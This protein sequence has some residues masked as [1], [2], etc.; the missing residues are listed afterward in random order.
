VRQ[1]MV[2]VFDMPITIDEP[3][4]PLGTHVFTA[5]TVTDNGAGM[6]WNLMTIPT[7]ASAAEPQRESRRRSRHERPA[8]V[9]VQSGKPASDAAEALDRVQMPKEAV[10]RISELL[11][12]GSSLIISD[13]G[14]S[15]ETGRA[16]EFVVLTR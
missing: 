12:P 15:S 6:R 8:P 7:D 4:R 3:D 1:G 14:I 13:T 16:T 11:V 10:D 5:M 9:V 2:P